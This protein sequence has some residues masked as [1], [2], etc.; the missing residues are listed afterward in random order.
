[1]SALAPPSAGPRPARAPRLAARASRTP[2]VLL[3]LSGAVAL[4]V[5]APLAFLL[6]E[7]HGAGVSTIT[8]LVFRPLTATLL[9]NTVRLT[10]V[11]TLLCAVIGT[12]AAW[13]VERTDLPGRRVWAVLVVVPL[14]IPDFVVS[15][16]WASLSTWVQ[17]FR[18]AVLVMT[19]AIYPLVYLPVAAS[20]R[21]SDPGQE[22]VARTLGAGRLAAF[23]RVTLGQARVA[24]LGGCVLVALVLLAEYGAFEIL[25]Y[26]TF[27]TEI[28]TEFNVSFNEPAACALSLVLVLMCLFVLSGE[29]L[30]RGR[31][32][33]SRAGALAQ[34]VAEP[35]RLGAWTPVVLGCFALLVGLALGVPVGAAVY[36]MLESGRGYLTGVSLLDAA[37][38]TAL[39]SGAAAALA[40]LMA[41]P[42]ALVASRRRARAYQLLERSTYLV[43]AMP[44]IVIAFA[45]SYF[46]ERYANGLLYQ[47]APLLV[48]AYA[49]LF[50]PL[51]LVAVRACL[52]QAP[53]ALE[54]VA[55]SLAQR[56]AAVLAR[57]TLPL[58]GPGLAAAFCL[59][60]LSAVTELTATLILI[61]TGVQTLS[62]QFWVYEQNL[63]YGQAAPF[64]LTMIAI[65][66][67]PS[68]VLGRFF[69][70]LPSR[71]TQGQ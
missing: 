16:G 28:F 15:F 50:F 39:Y 71:A 11:V 66:A 40:T 57:V 34:R 9:W 3:A 8:D 29:R 30:I 55:R 35:R 2:W 51:A 41:L 46:T 65:A 69:D 44:G 48:L 58:I 37:W 17:G 7:A 62:T 12:A 56:R 59:V 54:D 22:E 5:L 10:V 47:S 18:G 67:V 19:L 14:A 43:L 4:V 27:T 23:W 45:L 25:G 20:L 13:F 24:I 53:P 6:I 1:V 60:F 21:G 63:A 38:H 33:V 61:P 26:Q 49:V 68:Y 36:W 64:A 31:G 42:V 32:R 52:A 70:R